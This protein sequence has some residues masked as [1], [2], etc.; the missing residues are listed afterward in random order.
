MRDGILPEL[1]GFAFDGVFFAILFTIYEKRREHRARMHEKNSL[2]KALRNFLNLLVFWAHPAKSMGN[3][4]LAI[5]DTD[6]LKNLIKELQDAGRVEGV[7][8]LVL[9]DIATREISSF[10]ALLPVAAVIDHQHLKFWYLIINSLKGIRDS[11][12]DEESYKA[13]L[14]LIELLSQFDDIR[15]EL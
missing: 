9:R 2:K 10:E 14:S 13:L 7:Q 15:I 8:S 11:Q 3:C 5:I 12:A 6:S 1:I 4:D